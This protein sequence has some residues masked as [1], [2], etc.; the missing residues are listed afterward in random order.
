[1]LIRPINESDDKPLKIILRE[2]LIEMNI[3]K[4]GSA[5][6]DPEIDNM[7]NS[8]SSSR[9]RYFVVEENNKVLGGAGI[10]PLKDGNPD[11]CELQKMYFHKS[12]RGKGIGDKLS[13]IHI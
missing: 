5:Y 7:Y 11:V 8:Y 2:V 6:E 4:T 3:P 13:L 10:N 1:M 12:I 9:S